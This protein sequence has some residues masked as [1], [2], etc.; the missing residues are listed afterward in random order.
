M[1][2][3]VN[4]VQKQEIDSSLVSLYEIQVSTDLTLYFHPGLDE[5]L[6]PIRFRDRKT[7]TIIRT[8]QP[9]PMEISGIEVTSDGAQNRPSITIAN[10]ATTFRDLLGGFTN[11]DLIGSKVTRRQ[12]LK[13]YLYTEEFDSNPPKEFPV[14]SF[15]IDRIAQENNLLIEFELSSPFDLNGIQLPNRVVI[16]KYCS[17]IYQGAETGKGGCV[18]PRDS[19]IAVKNSSG[20]LVSHKVYYNSDDEP[21]VD[22]AKVSGAYSDETTYAKNIFVSHLGGFWYSKVSGNLGNTP[23]ESAFWGRAHAATSWTA[24]SYDEGDHVEHDST[25]WKAKVSHIASADNAP[26]LNSRVWARADVCGKTLDSCKKRFQFVPLTPDTALS[27][28]SLDLD[29]SNALPFGGFPGSLKF[30]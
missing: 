11:Q 8:Y 12:T 19:T 9:M 4:K 27:V 22:S 7:P 23:A 18:W 21:I 26:R 25:A 15:I 20:V 2:S 13:K 3:L 30:K 28:P 29:T 10:V 24:G 14:K 6:A 5:D 1:N 17:W 16:G